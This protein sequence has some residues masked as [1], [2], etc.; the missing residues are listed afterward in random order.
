MLNNFLWFGAP[1]LHLPL[2]TLLC[3]R[4][5]L[6]SVPIFVET[7]IAIPIS[8]LA[9]STFLFYSSTALEVWDLT[10]DNIIKTIHMSTSFVI[11]GMGVGLACSW[12]L[13]QILP[14]SYRWSGSFCRLHDPSTRPRSLF[15]PCSELCCSRFVPLVSDA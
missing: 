15:E 13:T 7:V 4:Y 9:L 14:V 10:L 12:A 8:A 5:I 3:Q 6:Q 1:V 2:S 11:V